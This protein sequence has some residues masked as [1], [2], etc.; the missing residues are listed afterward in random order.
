MKILHTVEF[1]H[2]S[3]GGMQ[4]VVKQI[5]ERLAMFDHEVTVAT[6]KLSERKNKII[7]GVKIEEFDIRGNLVNGLKGETE[8]YKEFLINSDFDI[9][10]NFAAQQW[11]SDLAF[12][13]LDRIKAKKVFVPTGFSE[14]YLP[15]YK[16]Y[17][18]NMK[19]WMKKYDMNVFLSD[20]YRDINF[21]RKNGIKKII[22]IPNGASEEEFLSLKIIDIRKKLNIPNN[23]FLIL[24]VGS[25]TGSK[26]HKEA[27]EI[28]DK[29]KI[30]NA[31]FLIIG[32]SFGGGCIK[33]CFIKEKLFNL[34]LKRFLDKKRLIVVSLSRKETVNAYKQADLFLFPSNI[35][36]SP[37]VLFECM[38]SKTPFLTT[39]V[40]NAK[41]IISWSRSGFLLPT[42]KDKNGYSKAKIEESAKILE[43]IFKNPTKRKTMA[44]KGFEDWLSKFTWKK[45]TNE[46]EKLYNKLSYNS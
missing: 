17:F 35:E 13:I 31:T 30:T 41:E 25:H 16:D 33:Y 36:C 27:I 21:A 10:A 28:F 7:N 23:H 26:G 1:Y 43:E 11:G 20:N 18:K 2:P 3:V 15:Q 24:H 9:I 34:S 14:F 40:G 5:S 44:E 6:T 46:Y 39:D 29:A 42:D 38:A 12:D 8:K 37:L 45:I 32:N 22:V 19:D 4:E